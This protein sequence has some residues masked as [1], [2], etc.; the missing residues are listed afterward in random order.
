[1]GKHD[2]AGNYRRN[3]SFTSNMEICLLGSGSTGNCALIRAG[4]GDDRV[5]V[6]LDCGL[7]QRTARDLAAS[8][9]VSL[10][11][12]D[13]VLLSHHHSDH[14]LNVVGVAARA[15]A[16]LYAH[17]LSLPNSRHIRSSELSRRKIRFEPYES[18]SSFTIGPL[19]CTPVEV[20]H[21]ANPTH[22][23]LFEAD[24]VRAGFFT[25][26]GHAD[27]L[28]DQLL[29]DLSL[30][31]LEFNHDSEMLRNGPYPYVLQERVG[32][33]LGHLSND[34]AREIV[35]ANAPATL[36]ELACAHLSLKNNTENLAW[37]AARDGIG[38]SSAATARVHLA[39]ARGVLRLSV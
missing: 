15:K 26:L 36:R 1:M 32:G 2:V 8:V 10:A 6:V 34:Q 17:P 4:K 14:C 3:L 31:V 37:S 25:D 39:P 18:N 29:Q 38:R 23:F 11:H 19:V 13:A 33:P 30:L 12:V 5:H 35:A 7:A 28:T 16:P 22:G 20:P 27:P 24:G 21:D 9:D